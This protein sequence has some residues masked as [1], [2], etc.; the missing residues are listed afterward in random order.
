MKTEVIVCDSGGRLGEVVD[1]VVVVVAVEWRF[2]SGE[3][4][5][6]HN[7]TGAVLGGDT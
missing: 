5:S 7:A 4:R 2:R 3:G 1:I 6:R